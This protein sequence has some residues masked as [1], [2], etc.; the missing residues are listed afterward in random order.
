[1]SVS[2]SLQ[3]KIKWFNIQHGYGFITPLTPIDGVQ[4]VFVH[5]TSI[6]TARDQYKYLVEGEYVQFILDQSTS[7]AHPYH[8]TSITG[9]QGGPLLCE[10]RNSVMET[11]RTYSQTRE[12]QPSRNR[13]SR[14][15]RD[16]GF[17]FPK[18]KNRARRN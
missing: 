2:P 18:Q 14:P 7:D 9:I 8:A 11:N 4:D 13:E 1:M 17:E 6:I 16:D 12:R 10:T 15:E 5:H 3:G